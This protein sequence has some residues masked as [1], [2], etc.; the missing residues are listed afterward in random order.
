MSSTSTIE[1]FKIAVPDEA[2]E[3]LRAKLQLATLPGPTDFSDDPN[4]GARLSDIERLVSYWRDQYD[5]RRAEADLNS[6]LPQFT[7][8]VA[9]DGHGDIKIHFVHQKSEREDSIPLLFCHGC[10]SQ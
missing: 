7:T 8:T 2:L 4:Y 9:V 10:E 6:K 3:R 5:W 1:P